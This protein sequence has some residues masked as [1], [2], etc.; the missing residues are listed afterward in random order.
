MSWRVIREGVRR[1]NHFGGGWWK[2]ERAAGFPF[3]PGA[4]GTMCESRRLMVAKG[5]G[6]AGCREDQACVTAERASR[7]GV[8]AGAD[9]GGWIVD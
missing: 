5:T 4:G 8:R 6:A 2:D 3:A 9:Q 7:A 1:G